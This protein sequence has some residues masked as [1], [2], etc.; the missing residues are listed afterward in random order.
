M[1]DSGTVALLGAALIVGVPSLIAALYSRAGSKKVTT[2][3]GSTAG[4]YI[5]LVALAV[6]E[7]KTDRISD[8]RAVHD[9]L[10]LAQ[11]EA[12]TALEASKQEVIEAVNRAKAEAADALAEH[13]EQDAINFA[14]IPG[15]IAEA[16][17]QAG[18][19]A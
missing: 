9:S 3:D 15:V 4:N 19:H 10:A 11:V 5:E 13:S 17:K 1:L 14:A 6:T 7:L 12:A 16:L 8:K 2:S 18:L